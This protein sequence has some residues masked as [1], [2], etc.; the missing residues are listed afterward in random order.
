M[1]KID[2]PSEAARDVA[3]EISVLRNLNGG[4]I[5][6]TLDDFWHQ[7]ALEVDASSSTQIPVVAQNV[8]LALGVEF[9]ED[10]VDSET[11]LPAL[12]LYEGILAALRVADAAKAGIIDALEEE[13]DDAVD[14]R[15]V[16][17]DVPPREWTIRETMLRIGGGELILNPEWQRGFV[18]KLQK[19]RRLIESMLLGLPIPSFLFF[20]DSKTNRIYVIDGR[21]RLETISRFLAP[22]EKKGEPKTRFRTFNAKT[23][24]WGPG[25]PLHEASNRYFHDLPD[26]F[27]GKFERA[28]I[29]TFTFKD[30]PPEQL[31]QIF[32][33]YNTGAVAL[34]AAEIRNAVYQASALHE[35]MFR[36]GGESRDPSKYRDPAEA[37]AGEVIRQTMPR[38]KLERYGAYDFIGRYF[39]FRYESSGSVSAATNTFMHRHANDGPEQVERFRQ[40]FIA[41]VAKTTEWYPHPLIEPKDDGAFNAMLGAIQ[42]VSTSVA[43]EAI[44]SGALSEETIRQRIR[45]EWP[46]FAEKILSEKQNSTLFWSS[47]QT[48]NEQLRRP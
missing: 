6:D 15:S 45:D 42:L 17:A 36:L 16:V 19:Q 12:S 27:K 9:D 4:H 48:W 29:V 46:L 13:E 33:R 40:E 39:A 41:A 44:A 37:D 26:Q 34:N 32:K 38:G 30:I 2:W 1:A 43:L 24:G 25:Q 20:E 3:S 10:Y 11:G 5:S 23:Q 31:Y 18:W 35:M 8:A 14:L 7:L 21:Q 22:K 28:P 47:H